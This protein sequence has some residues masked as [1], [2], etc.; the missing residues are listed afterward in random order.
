MWRWVQK[1]QVIEQIQNSFFLSVKCLKNS[2]PFH[3]DFQDKREITGFWSQDFVMHISRCTISI[4]LLLVLKVFIS[5][6]KGRC[7]QKK[8]SLEN[9]NSWTLRILKKTSIHYKKG[10]K[11]TL[12]ISSYFLEIELYISCYIITVFFESLTCRMRTKKDRWHKRSYNF[13]L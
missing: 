13:V 7:K 8:T 6:D 1:R 4:R 9:R 5:T 11:P 2:M 3:R 10:G 12:G